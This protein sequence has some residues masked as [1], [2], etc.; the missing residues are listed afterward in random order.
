MLLEAAGSQPPS[1]LVG[2]PA[3]GKDQG[4]PNEAQPHYPCGRA[5]DN[6]TQIRVR[7]NG[8][9]HAD[10]AAAPPAVRRISDHAA[11]SRSSRHCDAVAAPCDAAPS[12]CMPG[13]ASMSQQN[14]AYSLATTRRSQEPSAVHAAAGGPIR[15]VLGWASGRTPVWH[16]PSGDAL[17]GDGGGCGAA[18]ASHAMS[19]SPSDLRAVSLSPMPMLPGDRTP[20]YIPSCARSSVS[21]LPHS[22]GPPAEAAGPYSSTR[23]FPTPQS[24]SYTPLRSS[25]L[26]GCASTASTDGDPTLSPRVPAHSPARVPG[27]HGAPSMHGSR[28][29]AP[30][31][32]VATLPSAP[33]GSGS[34]LAGPTM[35]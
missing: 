22:V 12:L 5:D 32:H 17:G 24:S 13:S 29:G 10:A 9:A 27:V 30:H 1:W 8:S 34:F 23:P 21:P 4:E 28:F 15:A 20:L 19:P 6:M 7:T 35:R 26:A 31:Q 18:P 3:R 2:S 33:R 14:S 11:D 16:G 25:A